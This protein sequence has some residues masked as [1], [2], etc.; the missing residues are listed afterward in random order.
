[1]K[2]V[3]KKP[4]FWLAT[5]AVLFVLL[6]IPPALAL[7]LINSARNGQ[8]STVN[9]LLALGVAP[10]DDALGVA[11]YNGKTAVVRSLLAAGANP[12]AMNGIDETALAYAAEYGHTEVVRLMLAYGADPNNGCQEM[13]PLTVARA[14]HYTEIVKLLKQAGAKEH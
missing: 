6:C 1:M 12:N 8:V 2:S 9:H 3:L 7:V 4:K 5:I 14:G 10:S 11:A 13:D